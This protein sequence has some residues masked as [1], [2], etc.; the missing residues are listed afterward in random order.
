MVLYAL[1]TLHGAAQIVQEPYF[2]YAFLPPALWFAFDKAVSVAKGSTATPLSRVLLHPSLVTELRLKKP[3]NWTYNSGQWARLK[4]LQ[5]SSKEWHPFTIS[6]APAE[7]FIG[8][9][10]RSV[11]PW[12]HKMRNVFQQCLDSQ[13]SLPLVNIEGPFGED[14]QTWWKHK[15]IVLVGAGIGVTPFL[16]IIKDIV[17]SAKQRAD[18]M[19]TNCVYFCWVTPNL[20]QYEWCMDIIRQIE[21]EPSVKDLIRFQAH[22][23][24][25]KL[26]KDAD[27]RSAIYSSTEERFYKLLKRSLLSGLEAKTQFGRPNWY[28]WF[29]E[30]LTH[31]PELVGANGHPGEDVAIFSCCSP[32]IR[33]AI[34]IGRHAYLASSTINSAKSL[35]HATSNF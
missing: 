16:S 24:V 19:Q 31:D 32:P 14:H 4:I 18:S 1:M 11:G 28:N 30:T 8:F 5:V 22:I 15:T 33:K 25:T 3:A 34:D 7:Q 17:L 13:H 23:F 26:K 21:N 35:S 10:I 6:S 27:F 29:K 9:H 2:H 20:V 12:T